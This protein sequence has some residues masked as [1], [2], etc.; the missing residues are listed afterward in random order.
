M[1]PSS[2]EQMPSWAGFKQRFEQLAQSPTAPALGDIRQEALQEL[3]KL[4]F[5]TTKHE[6]WKY[7]NVARILKNEYQIEPLSSLSPSD[8]KSQVI[9][10]VEANI[11]VFVNG[12]YQAE[13]SQILCPESELL[14][15]DFS[16]A[17]REESTI[18]QQHFARHTN[19]REE[20][21]TALNTALA[22]NG[23]FLHVPAGVSV[24]HP[25]LLYYFQDTREGHIALNPRNFFVVGAGGSLS[26]LDKFH[27]I[28]EHHSFTNAVSEWIIHENAQ[29]KHYKVQQDGPQS[30]YIGTT[31]VHQSQDSV[32]SNTT[33]SLDG[34][35]IRNNLNILLDGSNI[36]S[37]MYGLYMLQGKTHVDN[38]T[39]A[40]HMKPHSLSNE[41]Y[42][43]ILEDHST[44]VFNGKI[45]V[46]QDA[47][48]TNAYQQ[49]RNVL[50]SDSATINT[51]PQLEI[52]ADDVKCSHGATTGGLDE[53]AMFYLRSRGIPFEE[54]RGLLIYAFANEIVD[55]IQ[56][57]PIRNYLEGQIRAR[58][59]R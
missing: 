52:W 57:E 21:F 41:L 26:V 59:S 46:R 39:I 20:A 43:G 35:L 29:V 45:F 28:G 14:I 4:G 44:G 19:Y 3:E 42:K 1:N 6:E 50:L 40:D 23:V 56:E 10:E 30:F 13:H 34:G 11:L 47:Q 54:A 24:S 58:L 2:L 9:P 7:T 15:R 51:K 53:N 49:N 27:T 33:I 25:V 38:H 8:W 55:T 12:Q 48:K 5:P 31:Q 37:N 17:S 32:Y 16:Q 22:Q 18:F 36:E